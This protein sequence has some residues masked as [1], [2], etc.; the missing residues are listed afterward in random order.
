M[1]SFYA[2]RQGRP[3]LLLGY[4]AFDRGH[5]R[6]ARRNSTPPPVPAWTRGAGRHGGASASGRIRRR[7]V[8]AAEAFGLS[9][10][11]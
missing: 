3:A 8:K 10:P 6:R 4:A 11:P 9:P 2:Q 5:L 7:R 1:S